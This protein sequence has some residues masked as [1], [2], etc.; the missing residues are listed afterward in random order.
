MRQAAAQLASSTAIEGGLLQ[1]PARCEAIAQALPLLATYFSSAE[2]WELAVQPGPSD[3][4]AQ[5]DIEIARAL[6]LRVLLALAEDLLAIIRSIA[7]RPTFR[8]ATQEDESSGLLAGRLDIPRYTQ[9]RGG[10][11]APRAYP[12]RVVER[13][14]ATPENLLALVALEAVD[15]AIASAPLEILPESGPERRELQ[16]VRGDLL[17]HRQLPFVNSL[18]F[19]ARRRIRGLTL[20]QGGRLV[21]RRLERGDIARAEPYQQLCAWVHRFR[22]GQ[23]VE[24]GLQRWSFY[25]ERFD[26][27]LFEIWS[28]AC[29][30]NLIS[31]RFGSPDGDALAPL[32][33][34]GKKPIAV[35]SLPF[36]RIELFFQREMGTLGLPGRWQVDGSSGPLRAIPD[37]VIRACRPDGESSWLVLDCKLRPHSPLPRADTKSARLDLPSEEIYKLLGYFDNLISDTSPMGGLIYYTPGGNANREMTASRPQARQGIAGLLGVD[38]RDPKGAQEA[39]SWVL[40]PIHDYLLGVDGE[41]ERAARE[42]AGQACAEG[43]DKTEADAAYKQ[44]LMVEVIRSYAKDHQDQ[45]PAIQKL[46]ASWFA[47]EVWDGLDP[48]TRRMVLSAELYGSTQLQQLDHSGPLL[49]LSAACERELNQRLFAPVHEMFPNEKDSQGEPAINIH[50]TLG[51]AIETMH[52]GRRLA[53]LLSESADDAESRALGSIRNPDYA[54]AAKLTGEYFEA[55]G[56]SLESVAAL[57][58]RL[59]KLNVEF[60]RPA[61]H[62]EVVEASSWSAGRSLMLGADG[63]LSQIVKTLEASPARS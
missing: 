57:V 18:A 15:R 17:R 52:R 28:L 58:K 63:V 31:E 62:D 16:Q 34:R 38:P 21:Q 9:R 45:L 50:S 42:A 47:P 3:R 6:R 14:Q 11:A 54:L 10:R 27:R 12:I 49:V 23:D 48:D 20:E 26:P 8:Y 53:T 19:E 46:T 22:T 41:A 39:L 24:F 32:W 61:A 29:I 1:A 35:W 5:L 4:E 30:A 37:L 2:T 40:G 56:I 33:D 13:D 7:A 43:L 55:S 60:R 51:G 25:D 59:R 44:R 36:G